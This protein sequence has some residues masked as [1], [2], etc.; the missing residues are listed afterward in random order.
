[1]IGKRKRAGGGIENVC[2]E[3]PTSDQPCGMQ[4]QRSQVPSENPDIEKGI[5]RTLEGG[6]L[7]Q[8][9]KGQRPREEHRR[10]EERGG[11]CGPGETRVPVNDVRGS[12]GRIGTSWIC[13]SAP[14][15]LI[16]IRHRPTANYDARA[17][18]MRASQ[19]REESRNPA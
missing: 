8:W 16:S 3:H 13:S 4:R 1:M 5:A 6:Q 18:S 14:G 11:R 9:V 15:D 19:K 10:G 17:E 12:P 7:S 2:V